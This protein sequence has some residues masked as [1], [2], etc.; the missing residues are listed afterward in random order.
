MV[1]VMVIVEERHLQVEGV[2]EEEEEE[3]QVLEDQELKEK[4]RW[5]LPRSFPLMKNVHQFYQMP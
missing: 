5:W 3:D 4:N 1:M 2:E